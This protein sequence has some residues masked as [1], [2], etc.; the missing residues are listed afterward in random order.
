[1]EFVFIHPTG[2]FHSQNVT[3][4]SIFTPLQWSYYDRVV[5]HVVNVLNPL[6]RWNAVSNILLHICPSC[7]PLSLFLLTILGDSR[8][9]ECGMVFRRNYNHFYTVLSCA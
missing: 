8:M 1:M 2:I 9:N 4:Q 5:S 7:L 3:K 6:K